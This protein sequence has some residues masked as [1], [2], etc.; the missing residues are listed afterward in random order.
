MIVELIA[1]FIGGALTQ[2]F[3]DSNTRSKLKLIFCYFIYLI[4]FI[5]FS[6]VF[7]KDNKSISIAIAIAGLIL[8]APISYV[9]V[10]GIKALVAKK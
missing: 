2:K 7:Y 8:S 4:I 10:F 6:I 5:C 9:S 1:E 3:M